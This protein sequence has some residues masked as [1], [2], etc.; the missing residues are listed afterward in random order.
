MIKQKFKALLRLVMLCACFCLI[1]EGCKKEKNNS[2]E[3][4]E[5][6]KERLSIS[7]STF[8]E[9]Y[10]QIRQSKSK[11]LPLEVKNNYPRFV[12]L[13]K[14]EPDKVSNTS[15]S[16]KP[17][18]KSLPKLAGLHDQSMLQESKPAYD[19]VMNELVDDKAF[20]SMLNIE[21]EI[22]VDNVIYKVTPYGTFFTEADNEKALNKVFKDIAVQNDYT[23][24]LED[25][26]APILM[27]A[28][29][30]KSTQ[31]DD[32]R[33]LNNSVYFVDSFIE[34]AMPQPELSIFP[35]DVT[36]D[37][38]LFPSNSYSNNNLPNENPQSSISTSTYAL[39]RLQ[40]NFLKPE[41][42]M[43]SPLTTDEAY[44]NM[45]EYPIEFRKGILGMGS[46]LQT[47]FENSTRYHNFT[48][49]YRVSALMYNRNYGILKTIGIKVK[50]QKKGWFWWNKTDAQEIRAGWDY[51][52]YVSPR[53]VPKISLPSNDIAPSS[54]A[55]YLINPYEDPFYG[56]PA[57]HISSAA[58]RY[59]LYGFYMKRGSNELFTIMIP[60]GLV[61]FKPDGLAVPSS[62]FKNAIHSGWNVLKKIL[63]K[64]A[65][66]SGPSLT[67]SNPTNFKF[68]IYPLNGNGA[69]KYLSINDMENMPKA[70]SSTIERRDIL[71]DNKIA[72]F[73]SPYETTAYNTD[74]IDI[75][76]DASSVDIK[77]S[78]D[79]SKP[80]FNFT[81]IAKSLLS[82]QL[83]EGYE[84][85]GAS[86]FGAVRWNNQWKGIRLNVKMKD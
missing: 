33:L 14:H 28:V 12:S 81:Q 72:T 65:P 71:D 63:E 54:G 60:G 76:F 24:R 68:P 48:N 80:A 19:E 42:I 26:V 23:L 31:Y 43:N 34:K 44:K 67:N 84:V 70:Y 61:P 39:E 69:I 51:I 57:P 3:A 37:P 5:K 10:T 55:Y 6:L 11:E 1:A 74:M 56:V 38:V 22:E 66:P 47:F 82:E 59:N 29:Q 35:S 49:K 36:L 45:I 30:V 21:G 73:V 2:A 64:S 25:Q 58:K 40:S 41:A 86:I 18:S 52:S 78:T 4:I 32:V 75:P 16:L 53:S 83:G 7:K 15:L 85:K 79:P 13:L 8:N 20:K 46:I 50:C 17:S 62:K 77:F 27:D 9:L